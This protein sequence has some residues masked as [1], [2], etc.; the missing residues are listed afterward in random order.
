[1][2]AKLILNDKEYEIEV[3]EEQIKEIKKP[4]YKRW[5]AE[6]GE[7]YY[8]LSD[9]GEILSAIDC[10][11][12][13]DNF[14]YET[15]NYS[16]TKE[17]LEEKKKKLLYRQQYKD[18]LGEDLVTEDDWKKPSLGKHATCIDNYCNGLTLTTNNYL[19]IQGVI[20]SNSREKI[21]NFINLIGEDNFKKYILEVE[22]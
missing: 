19:K 16:E 12:K 5:R 11:D 9:L 4:K 6:E 2:K 10:R 20:Y 17:V 1:M 15:G 14:R 13:S 22:E 8:F 7:E 21:E 18:Y 3:S